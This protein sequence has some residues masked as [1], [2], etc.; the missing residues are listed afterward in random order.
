MVFKEEGTSNYTF[1]WSMGGE[2]KEFDDIDAMK[3]VGML[4][5]A[6]Y[7]INGGIEAWQ[8]I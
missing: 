7:K 1:I 8:I 6:V 4:Y 3:P 2:N 5:L